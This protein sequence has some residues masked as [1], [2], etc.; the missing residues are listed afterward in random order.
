MARFI[1]DYIEGKADGHPEWAFSKRLKAELPDEF[2]V[3]PGLELP[4]RRDHV[5]SEA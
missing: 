2:I 3:I 4:V 1:P 5:E